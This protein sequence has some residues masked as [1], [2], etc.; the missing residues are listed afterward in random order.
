MIGSHEDIQAAKLEDVHDFFKQYYAPNNASIAIVG[1]FDEATTRAWIEKYFG[2]IPRGPEVEPVDV[3]TAP[4]T[5]ER[6]AVVTDK[7]ELPRVFM[8]WITAPILTPGDA[9]ADIAAQI[10]AGGKASRLYK[11]LVYEQ[12]IAQDVEASQYSLTL[13][14]VFEVTVTAKPG[15][16]AQE[17]EEAIDA[18]LED[19]AA[20]GP[21]SGRTHRRQERDS[22][23]HRHEPGEAGW[24]RRR[25]GS[26]Q[27][28]QPPSR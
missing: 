13:G 15:H 11:S 7:V 3:H 24:L 17:I 28:L 9:E 27:L 5:E 25:R 18:E 12:K 6:R 21:T 4:I 10:F 8:G 20:N 2:S 23:A 26:A 22:V 16:S 1:D 14:S 19:F